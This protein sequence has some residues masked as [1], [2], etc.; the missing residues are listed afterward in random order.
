MRH[1]SRR[2]QR[3][4]MKLTSSLE[5][6][7][8]ATARLVRAIAAILNSARRSETDLGHSYLA[9]QVPKPPISVSAVANDIAAA[10]L[11]LERI[12]CQP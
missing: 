5:G 10:S 11:D 4:Q 8:V 9:V 12:S 2:D 7:G 3:N 1:G 6:K